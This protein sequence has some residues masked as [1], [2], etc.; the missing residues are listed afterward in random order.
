[1]PKTDLQRRLKSTLNKLG[2]TPYQVFIALSLMSV[3]GSIHR[4]KPDPVHN[5]LLEEDPALALQYQISLAGNGIGIPRGVRAFLGF[6]Y[7]HKY[8]QLVKE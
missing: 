4:S 1:M 3:K 5:F 6:F 8:P 7:D 2:R